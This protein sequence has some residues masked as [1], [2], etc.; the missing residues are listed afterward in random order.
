VGIKK[1]EIPFRVD[2]FQNALEQLFGLGARHLE[3]LFIKNLHEK[4]KVTYKWDMPSCVVPEL[5]FHEYLRIVK[6]KFEDSGINEKELKEKY[7]W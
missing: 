2:D 6:Q 7:E 3:I 4:L 1:R 5:T